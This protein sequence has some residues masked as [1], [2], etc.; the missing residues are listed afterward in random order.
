MKTS[1]RIYDILI[2]EL[3]E[4]ENENLLADTLIASM[5]TPILNELG[6]TLIL[7]PNFIQDKIESIDIARATLL[8][9]RLII[10]SNLHKQAD[11]CKPEYIV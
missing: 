5:D 3:I 2:Q 7:S 1:T 4:D 6:V 9:Q 10:C 11:L 8:E